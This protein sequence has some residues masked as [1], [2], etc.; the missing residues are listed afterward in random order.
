MKTTIAEAVKD[1]TADLLNTNMHTPG[2]R[3]P[4]SSA[5]PGGGKIKSVYEEH[6]AEIKKTPWLAQLFQQIMPTGK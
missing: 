4:G 3:E 6:E 1:L 5:N 2:A